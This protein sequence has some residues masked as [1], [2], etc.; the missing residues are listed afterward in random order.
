MSEQ[1]KQIFYKPQSR[2]LYAGSFGD[3]EMVVVSDGPLNLG[4]HKLG[5]VEH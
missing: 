2:L 1:I 5:F 4:L 3:T